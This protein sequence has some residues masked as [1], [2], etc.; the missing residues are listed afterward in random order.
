MTILAQCVFVGYCINDECS[1]TIKVKLRQMCWN[2]EIEGQFDWYSVE[3]LLL[4]TH[5][6]TALLVAGCRELTPEMKIILFTSE[7]CILLIKY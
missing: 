4:E 1:F 5:K 2:R 6:Q 3:A 7:S